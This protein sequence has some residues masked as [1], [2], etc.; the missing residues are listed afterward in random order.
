MAKACK[1]KQVMAPAGENFKQ[2]A[3][4]GAIC[5]LG[6]ASY[7]ASQGKDASHLYKR[8]RYGPGGKWVHRYMKNDFACSS[9]GVGLHID[10]AFGVHK[11][12]EVDGQVS[13]ATWKR[14]G[15]EGSVCDGMSTGRA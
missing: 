5:R 8:V 4:E 7:A 12:C 1:I 9:V 11:V 6:L 2:R 3:T 14:C 13:E 10:P 15:G